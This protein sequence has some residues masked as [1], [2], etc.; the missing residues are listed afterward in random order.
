LI[1]TTKSLTKLCKDKNVCYTIINFNTRY[2]LKKNNNNYFLK[3]ISLITIYI[4]DKTNCFIF[5]D[6]LSPSSKQDTKIII[7]SCPPSSK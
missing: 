6:V 3:Y 7:M 2:K 5:D 1:F 4:K